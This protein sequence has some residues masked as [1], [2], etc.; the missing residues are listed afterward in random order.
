MMSLQ[1][2]VIVLLVYLPTKLD[3]DLSWE[4]DLGTDVLCCSRLIDVRNPVYAV[5]DPLQTVPS[6][7]SN[8][9][10]NKW[11]SNIRTLDAIVAPLCFVTSYYCTGNTFGHYV[12][13]W[14]AS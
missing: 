4:Y 13:Q 11:I 7:K 8:I 12:M 6:H 10:A 2:A 1:E 5:K 9:N 3:L 14:Y